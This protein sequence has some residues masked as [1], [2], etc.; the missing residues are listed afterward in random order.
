MYVSFL[1]YFGVQIVS[2]HSI[3]IPSSLVDEDESVQ[4]KLKDWMNRNIDWFEPAMDLDASI[5]DERASLYG[6]PQILSVEV[7]DNKVSITYVFY[8]EAYYGCQD[9]NCSGRS[10][11]A[12]IDAELENNILFFEEFI[13]PDKRSTCDEF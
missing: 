3:T 7:A 12:W 13:P 2:T 10:N 9:Q 4:D 6:V 5:Y 11:Q 1:Y 8:W